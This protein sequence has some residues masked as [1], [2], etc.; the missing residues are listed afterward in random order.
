MPARSVSSSFPAW[1]TKGFPCR[2]SLKPGASPTIMIW[3][4]QGP[5]PGTALVRVA[6]SPQRVQASTARCRRSSRCALES[7]S[8]GSLT[9]TQPDREADELARLADDGKQLVELRIRQRRQWQPE[10]TRLEAKLVDDH[11]DRNRVTGR[12]HQR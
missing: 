2:S 10:R 5:L 12:A 3:A 8:S 9:D 4:G 6:W 7:S 11:L 1:P